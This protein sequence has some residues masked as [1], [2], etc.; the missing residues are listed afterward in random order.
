M[1]NELNNICLKGL[2]NHT[3]AGTHPMPNVPCIMNVHNCECLSSRQEASSSPWV[4]REVFLKSQ[5]QGPAQT[6]DGQ[7]K[8]NEIDSGDILS[9]SKPIR[10]GDGS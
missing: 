6:S 3:V 2:L 8:L 10:T 7:Y 5:R 1:V 4:L 9:P